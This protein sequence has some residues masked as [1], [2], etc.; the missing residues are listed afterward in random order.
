MDDRRFDAWTRSLASGLSRRK[1][2]KGLIGGAVL[3]G[4]AATGLDEV[5]AQGCPDGQFLCNDTCCP[6]ANNCCGGGFSCTITSACEAARYFPERRYQG[7]PSQRQESMKRRN[8]Q[9]V[10]TSESLATPGS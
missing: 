4:A 6:N 5:A 9:N 7:T 8:A 2:L 3:G 1:V 10:S